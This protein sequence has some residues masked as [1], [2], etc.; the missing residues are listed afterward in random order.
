MNYSFSLTD[1]EEATAAH[2]IP[3]IQAWLDGAKKTM[4]QVAAAELQQEA[5]ENAIAE[6]IAPKSFKNKD[7]GDAWRAHPDYKTA[8]QK[9][10]KG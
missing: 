9:A 7:I 6:K 1:E 8:A 2:I 5:I 10:L 3:N 4:L